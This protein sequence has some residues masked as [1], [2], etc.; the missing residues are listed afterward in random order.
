MRVDGFWM[1]ACRVAD[2][3]ALGGYVE[4][5]GGWAA[6]QAGGPP[7]WAELGVPAWAIQRWRDEPPAHTAGI[8]VRQVD[9]GY[10]ACLR[11]LPDAPPVLFVDGEPSVV[12]RRAVAVVGTRAC[13]GYGR[14]VARDLG[15]ELASAGLVVVSGLARGI[16][17]AA[18]LG[19]LA[20]GATVAVLAH[21]LS[22]TAPPGHR[23]LR[24]RLIRAGGAVVTTWPDDVL[25]QKWS[26]PNRNRWI[27]G[28]S[29][30][31]VVV[32]APELSG[33]MHTVR[34]AVEYGREVHAV[35]GPIGAPASAGCLRLIAEG[36]SPV[37]SVA[38]LV[39]CASGVRLER[40]AWLNALFGGA[41]LD[42]AAR[43]KGGSIA[44]LLAELHLL[45]ARGLVVRLPGQRYAK[46]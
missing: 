2:R 43:V 29:E 10:P 5:G 11:P 3:L 34:A 32:E 20:R 16:D 8:A 40:D 22:H 18:H 19:A 14:S 39:A 46:A 36:A 13:T 9:A 35:P 27:A 28:L 41:S 23:E 17:A 21:G 44:E 1:G 33:A 7:L 45:E 42:E 31:V 12:G 38:E 25:P 15:G 30:R 26:F 37:V 24:E 4:R 6:M